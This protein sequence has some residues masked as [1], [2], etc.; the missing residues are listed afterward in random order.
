MATHTTCD[1]CGEEMKS[2]DRAATLKIREKGLPE[3]DSY[4]TGAFGMMWGGASADDGSMKLEMCADCLGH[5]MPVTERI[6]REKAAA[7]ASSPKRPNLAETELA[8][9]YEAMLRSFKL[10]K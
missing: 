8:A 6:R 1:F 5:L 9:Q 7:K 3:T 10:G 2:K 4:R